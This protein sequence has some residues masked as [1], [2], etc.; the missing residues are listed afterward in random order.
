MRLHLRPAGVTG[1][2]VSVNL[3]DV[4]G[5]VFYVHSLSAAQNQYY[6]Y[7][8][9]V[10]VSVEQD[11]TL[12]SAR[13]TQGWGNDMCQ[14]NAFI[15][16]YVDLGTLSTDNQYSQVY[17]GGT[18]SGGCATSDRRRTATLRIVGAAWRHDRHG[19]RDRASACV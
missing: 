3:D 19:G 8:V 11:Y 1:P 13:P 2:A 12:A 4:A 16:S 14:S 7:R 9:E 15:G 18:Y 5:R 6:C 17:S 10:G